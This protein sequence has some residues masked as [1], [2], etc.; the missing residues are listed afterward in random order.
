M[1][2]TNEQIK[3]QLKHWAAIAKKYQKPSVPRAVWQIIN[4]L[5]P[6]IGLWVVMYYS[7][8]WSYWITLALGIV[9]G[10]FLIRVFIIQHDCG[11][12][13]FFR[14]NKVNNIV[15]FFCSFF[16][17]IP[18]KFWAGTHAFHHN[19]N[20]QLEHTSIGDIK[21]L[22]VA[23]YTQLSMLNKVRYRAFRHPFVLF[24][25]GPVY[26]LGISCRLPLAKFNGWKKLW[27]SLTLN[28]LLIGLFYVGLG[29]LIGWKQFLMI[30]L[31]ILAVFS[32]VAIWFFYVQHQH[33]EAY[34]EWSG[35]WDYLLSAIKGS[36][37]YKLPK[38]M[39]WFSGNIGF[40]HIHHLNPNI[41]N[42]NLEQCAKENPVFQK[43]VTTITFKES[44]KC[45]THH[46]W[47][48][49]RQKMISFWEYSRR[50]KA[51]S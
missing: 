48:E 38:L 18:Y 5:G 34:K 21:T 24:V 16:S 17:S 41:P 6:F 30:Q 40:H 25:L 29:F 19:H 20:G 8:S 15:G 35:K 44:L 31:P 3:S 27:A 22:T 10:L 45:M 23:E 28:N 7:L 9:N 47:D 4:T 2:H 1:N 46:L 33:E 12:Q 49:N 51:K 42:Y 32:I 36:T 13:S 11:H 26:Y 37:Y 14:N 50:K 39:Q 43:F